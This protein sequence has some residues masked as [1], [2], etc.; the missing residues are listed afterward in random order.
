MPILA[1]KTTFN[2]IGARTI[3]KNAD[4]RVLLVGQM[5]SGTATAGTIY[6][7][8]P[9]SEAEINALF[10]ATSHMAEIVRQF[11]RTNKASALDVLPLADNGSAVDATATIAAAATSTASADAE[12]VVWVG[13]KDRYRATVNITAGDD[14]DA[15]AAAIEA[16]LDTALANSP[17]TASVSTRTV[18][19]TA[20]NGGT[21]A[22]NAPIGIEGTVPG[23]ALTLTAFASGATD[24]VLTGILDQAGNTRYQTIGWPTGYARTVVEAFLNARFNDEYRVL[25]GVAIQ[26][27]TDT[28]ANLIS[29]A[30][31]DNSSSVVVLGDITVAKADRKGGSIMA[32]NDNKMATFCAV[33]ALR[34]T[35]DA[36]LT[37][38]L[39]TV[40]SAD[41][42]GGAA[43]ATLP[44]Q[45]T[46][47]PFLPVPV[48][49]DEFSSTQFDGLTDA[50]YS[51]AGAN[52]AYNTTVLGQAVTT[53]K[54]N[55][56]GD[57]DTSFKW[58]NRV[59][60][61]SV[62]REYFAV[63][64]KARYAQTRLT[65]GELVAGRDM[66]NQ[67]SII[68]FS[69]R[70]YEN[71]A[72]EAVVEKGAAASKDFATNLLVT[73]S[74]SLGKVTINMAPLQVGQLRTFIGTI[75]VNFS[76]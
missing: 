70:L 25:D 27:K 4:Q 72:D 44:Y 14:Q 23:V 59:D 26:A 49:E 18:T 74:V 32:L 60:A 21:W 7:D 58:L 15:V 20:N 50:G 34:L 3:Q 11:K 64:Y 10:G 73:V 42:F 33:R 19:V 12:I 38:I 66:A 8:V 76:S 69:K 24:P 31:T 48:P 39:T 62:I 71:L 17:F 45:N 41:Q 43:L 37:G 55:A 52:P 53:Y 61:S 30:P 56:A 36:S 5:L 63:N 75:A 54:T 1:P 40:S 67:A 9:D 35:A 47:L 29:G 51:V 46:V 6:R 68:T 65:S 16:A 2:I 57:A 13:D 22:N 28:Y